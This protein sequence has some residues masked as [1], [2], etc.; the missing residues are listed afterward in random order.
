MKTHISLLVLTICLFACSKKH[1]AIAIEEDPDLKKAES[2]LYRQNDS[3]FYYYNK[4]ASNSKDSLQIAMAYNGMAAMLSDAGDYYGSQDYLLMS[5]H[6][7]DERKANS[8]PCFASDY[9][10]LGVT[11]LNLKNYDAAI[12]YADQALKYVE[13]DDF[14][15]T[16]LNN[17]ALAY[18]K[19]RDFP[20]AV[21]IYDS[22]IDK[23]PRD[24]KAY[25][26][27]LSNR[28]RT[29][30]LQDPSYNAAPALLAA[31]QIR[32][33]END[34]WGQN[35][36]YSHLADYYTHTHPDSALMYAD[37]MDAIARALD[38]PDDEVEALQKLIALSPSQNAKKY[39]ARYQYLSDSIQTARN[40]AKNQFA[41]IRYNA[42]KNKVENL[43]L[44]KENADKRN[45][46][47]QAYGIIGC[48]IGF[49]FF[50][51]F[52]LRKRNESR[53]RENNLKISQKVHDN[54]ANG[55][56]RL[57]KEIEYNVDIDEEKLL[58]VIERLYRKSRDI[59][60]EHELPANKKE[61]YQNEITDL[62]KTFNTAA[63]SVSTVGNSITLWEKVGVRAKKEVEYVLEELMVNMSK[64][65]HASRVVV[66]FEQRENDII[67]QYN[68]DGVGLL[69]EQKFGN[70]LNNTVSRIKKINGD[71][72][73]GTNAANGLNIQI[74][75]PTVYND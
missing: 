36:S 42:E 6:Y 21:A 26:R 59:S 32:T 5:L 10:E 64:H 43:R 8:R 72:T 60:Y 22:I 35:A 18:Q 62:L 53:I 65:S 16:I 48:T 49:V 73:F 47:L 41:L 31:L 27:I 7:L 14:K 52:W 51:I 74:S 40:T 56:Y 71:I 11:S 61:N 17:K 4:L 3:A 19:K 45:Q 70:G 39:F 67:I 44:Q 12:E 50:I 2:F 33:R 30:W 58:N 34:Q 69:P 55:L 75:F 54:V 23:R 63:T 37:K 1:S 29:R 38:S 57:M 20:S 46:L 13:D 9:N 28:A 25:S 68:D 15:L 24:K 66:K